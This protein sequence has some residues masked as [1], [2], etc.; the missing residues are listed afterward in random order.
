MLANKPNFPGQCERLREATLTLLPYN[1]HIDSHCEYLSA[2]NRA[3]PRYSR[4]DPGWE[5]TP[6]AHGSVRLTKR[7]GS[8]TWL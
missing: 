7:G 5:A 6:C 1:V 2:Q 3:W 8:G 4:R